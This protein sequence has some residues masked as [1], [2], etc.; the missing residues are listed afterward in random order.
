MAAASR[1]SDKGCLGAG[2]RGARFGG[3]Q[4]LLTGWRVPLRRYFAT[5]CT[6]SICIFWQIEVECLM[7][8]TCS[9][10]PLLATSPACLPSRSLC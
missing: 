10:L 5:V 2:D 3:G 4:R 7:V 6:S 9:P 8:R 1:Q